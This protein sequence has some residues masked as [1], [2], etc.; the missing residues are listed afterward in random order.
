MNPWYFI[1]FAF[2]FGAILIIALIISVILLIKRRKKV[3]VIFTAVNTMLIISGILFCCSHSTY[4][5]YNDWAIK[6]HNIN[7]IEQKYGKF[8]LVKIENNKSGRAAY[9]IYTDDGPI[10]PD[11]LK[12]Y[13]Y[14]EYD[15]W[16]VIYNVYDAPQP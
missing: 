14:M 13:Y 16:G 7:M 4:Y 15:C 9:Y 2:I 8:D 10:M 5:K 1:T 3:N 6:D 11:H 12:H